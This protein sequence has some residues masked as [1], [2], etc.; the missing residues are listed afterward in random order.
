MSALL[1]LLLT[2]PASAEDDGPGPSTSETALKWLR[3]SAEYHAITTQTYR[4][5][6]AALKTNKKGKGPWAAVLDVDETVL[7]NSVYQLER[8]TY[9]LPYESVS[10]H[11]WCERR[12]ATPVPGVEDFLAEVRKQGGRV[13]F[14]T[15]RKAV[16]T[17]ATRDNLADH[18]LY[19]DGDLLCTRTD[20]S[21]KAPRREQ[22]RT[23]EGPCSFDEPTRAAVYLGDSWGDFP[24]DGEETGARL[25]GVGSRYFVLPNPL[26]G[27]WQF[28]RGIT[29]PLP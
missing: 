9:D 5:A 16:V 6:T 23:G 17:E 4:Q 26:Y 13:V 20:T 8:H 7:D 12:Q 25:D 29:R 21:D 15:N 28:L 1:L 3:D 10:W 11:A 19:Q 24:A 22:V 2:A 18:G 14:L 27:E